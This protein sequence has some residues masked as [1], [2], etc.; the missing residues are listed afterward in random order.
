MDATADVRWGIVGPGRIAA[1]VVQDFA[2]VPGA[3]AVG[4]AS[5]SLDR[6]QSFV[7]EHTLDQA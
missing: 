7:D 4:A 1:K 3:V 6:A 2:H 5:R